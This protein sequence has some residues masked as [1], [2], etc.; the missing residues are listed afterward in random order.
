MSP[1]KATQEFSIRNKSITLNGNKPRKS[2]IVG[3]SGVFLFI[4]SFLTFSYQNVSVNSSIDNSS[5]TQTTN[6]SSTRDHQANAIS[7][8]QLTAAN[9]VASLAEV[10]NLPSAGDLRETA[11]TLSVQKQLSQSDSMVVSK[12]QIVKPETSSERGITDYK[13]ENGDN[14]ASISEKF[15][16]SPQTIKWANNMAADSVEVGAQLTIPRA[17][18]VVYTVKA[19]DSVDG[20]ASKYKVDAERVIMY[21]NLDKD[22]ELAEGARLLLPNGDLPE[23]ERPG[24]VAPR[25]YSAPTTNYNLSYSTMGGGSV[26][27]RG[28][29]FPGPSA[30]NRYAAGNCTWYAYERRAQLGRPIGG[31]WGNAYSWKTSAQNGGYQVDKN[32]TP[33]AV[34]QTSG[35]GGGYGH[36]GVVERIEGDNM[37]ISDMNYA[38]YN[39]V[40]WRTIPLSQ[41]GN[42]WYIH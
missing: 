24:Y 1:Q 6:Q 10:V 14:L 30:G 27:S 32:P 42:Y 36:V 17:D 31:M 3:Y 13:V 33:G 11:T 35:G 28:Y 19:G 23:T 41:A 21:N 34:I 12:P 37:I 4:V 20:I 2:T 25:V 39:V 22:A 18:G 5:V 26:I 9:A 16:V 29:G 15:G 7:A 8:D 40:T 38:G